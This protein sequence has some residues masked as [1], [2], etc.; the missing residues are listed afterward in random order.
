[1]VEET[2]SDNSGDKKDNVSLSDDD[3]ERQDLMSVAELQ[4]IVASQRR[5]IRYLTEKVLWQER[6][7]EQII[8]S[9]KISSSVLLERIK[10]LEA[11]QNVGHERP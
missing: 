1:M 9:F 6:E 4:Q 5:E 2:K 8:D 11:Q 3:R 7:K 10:D